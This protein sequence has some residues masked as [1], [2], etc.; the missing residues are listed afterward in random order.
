MIEATSPAGALVTLSG[1]GSDPDNDPLTFTW[2]ESGVTLGTG[3][4]ISITLPIGVHTITFAADDGRGGTGT[5]TVLVTVQDTTPPVLTMPANQTLEA[6]GPAGAMAVFS[7]SSTDLV[8]GARPVVCSP[9]SGSTFPLGATL[10]NCT[11]TDLHGNS[12]QG[13]FL[14]TVR[15]TTP[16]VLHV[17]L[18]PQILW[19]PNKKLIPITA[20]IQVNDLCDPNPTVTLVSISSNDPDDDPID[21]QGAV[22]G[23]D[24]RTFLLRARRADKGAS[25]VYTV[26]YRALDHS[27]NATTATAIV[28]VPQDRDEKRDDD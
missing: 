12:A 2:S 23:T 13:S 21:I 28:S 1:S 20:K 14:V 4:P 26:T 11:A 3:T 24:D 25:R 10:V 6:T 15:D 18:S 17:T 22:L 8:D 19:P 5:S 27:G 9:A 7:A 16:P